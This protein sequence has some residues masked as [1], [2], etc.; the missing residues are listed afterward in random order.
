MREEVDVR[1]ERSRE[2]CRRLR[3]LARRTLEA[4][5][6][7]NQAAAAAAFVGNREPDGE[8]LSRAGELLEGV[9]A[10]INGHPHPDG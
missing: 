1:N 8:R 3:E 6:S 2:E 7:L 4:Y 9:I 10:E 5:R